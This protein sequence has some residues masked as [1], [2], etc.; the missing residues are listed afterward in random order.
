MESRDE[1]GDAR[2]KEGNGESHSRKKAPAAMNLAMD[3][4]EKLLPDFLSLAA[5]EEGVP[6]MD[7]SELN[8]Q[9]LVLGHLSLVVSIAKRFC[10]RNR[11][12][13]FNDLFQEGVIGLLKA[14]DRYDPSRGAKLSAY[15]AWWIRQSIT[16]AIAD[17]DSTIR[18]PLHRRETVRRFIN[19]SGVLLQELGREPTLEEIAQKLECPLEDVKNARHLLLSIL[20]PQGAE[21]SMPPAMRDAEQEEVE[22]DFLCLSL[23]D[24]SAPGPDDD[25]SRR[26]LRE[27]ISSLIDEL[28]PLEIEILVR[29]FIQEETLEAI[30]QTKGVSRERIRQIEAAALHRLRHPSRT[31]RLRDFRES[32]E[33]P[34]RGEDAGSDS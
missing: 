1:K 7:A 5:D 21:A 18:L 33:E 34:S 4:E 10:R 2:Q 20:D 9:K 31:S 11:H 23:E 28:K 16:R 22:K 19:C 26:E 6:P 25:F 17:M 13:H 8:R 29:R 14:V 30:A 27:L 15:A 3:G 24:A 32:E 12:L